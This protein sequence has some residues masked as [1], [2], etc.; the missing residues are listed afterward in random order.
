MIKAKWSSYGFTNED[1]HYRMVCDWRDAAIADGWT[2]EPAYP[3]S[4]DW[5]ESCKLDKD[6][7]SAMVITRT[8]TAGIKWK[9]E[10]MVS[11]WGK[12]KLQIIAKFPYNWEDVVDGLTTCN[13]CGAKNV[14]TERYSFAGR[15]CKDCISE[16]REI[17][18]PANWY[19]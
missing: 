3:K 8:K 7:F 1:S 12:D 11:I 9:Y 4:E 2:C 10:A 6:G 18:E 5:T 14:H 17:H 13:N 19:E 16:M 15:C